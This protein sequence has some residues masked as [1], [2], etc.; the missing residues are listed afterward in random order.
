MERS[1][2]ARYAIRPAARFVP[3]RARDRERRLGLRSFGSFRPAPARPTVLRRS[4]LPPLVALRARWRAVVPA[5]RVRSRAG[6]PRPVVSIHWAD[7]RRFGT[8]R[9]TSAAAAPWRG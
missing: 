7:A 1:I 4:D 3:V 9:R 2:T 8:D 5:D 6:G